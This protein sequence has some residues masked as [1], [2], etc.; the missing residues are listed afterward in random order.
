ME[1]QWTR[2]SEGDVGCL[3]VYRNPEYAIYLRHIPLHEN[4]MWV[5]WNIIG[6]RFWLHHRAFSSLKCGTAITYLSFSE[7]GKLAGFYSLSSYSIARHRVHGRLARNTPLQIPT[8]LLGQ[9]GVDQEFQSQ[10]LG[11]KLLHDAVLRSL[12]VASSVG[13]RALVVEPV[14]ESAAQ[15]YH[16][17]GFEDLPDTGLLFYKLV[18]LPN[19]SKAE[20]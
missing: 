18:P 12:S 15:F 3:W 10:G 11:W 6:Y 16:R 19:R 1:D 8:I 14:S 4:G 7:S 20:A 9:L 17:F 2:S 5:E 13:S